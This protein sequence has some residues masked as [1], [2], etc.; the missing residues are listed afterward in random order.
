MIF[1]PFFTAEDT[2]AFAEGHR[3]KQ[4]MADFDPNEIVASEPWLK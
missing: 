3:G 2:E 1:N 4:L